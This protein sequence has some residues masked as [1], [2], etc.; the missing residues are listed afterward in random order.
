MFVL[1]LLLHHYLLLPYS[2]D[3][4]TVIALTVCVFHIASVVVVRFNPDIY[5]V[6]EEE[7]NST[8]TITL[9]TIGT[10][11]DTINVTVIARDDSAARG[12]I[13]CTCCNHIYKF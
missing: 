9:E 8:A 13:L 12:Y 11:P 2:Y 1:L 4:H 5:F 6:Q 10:H 7:M 3:V